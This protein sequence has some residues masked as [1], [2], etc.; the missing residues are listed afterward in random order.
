LNGL[1]K[2]ISIDV[3]LNVPE[4]PKF[5]KG[6]RGA[7]KGLAVVN[8]G[9][10]PELIEGR[11]GSFRMVESKGAAL[12]YLNDGDRVYT[13][14]QTRSIMRHV[15]HYA[16]GIGNYE[17]VSITTFIDK[18]PE[19]FDKAHDE[20]ELRRDMDLITEEEYYKELGRLRDDFFAESSDKWWEYTE[21]IYSWE[22]DNE[23]KTLDRRLK[24]GE[25]S[26]KEY[27]EALAE[28]RDKY[29]EEG[30]DEWWD[31][32][33][34]IRDYNKQI[35]EDNVQAM[36][37]IT[38]A[39]NDALKERKELEEQYAK[40]IKAI[41]DQLASDIK[42]R[43]EDL[44]SEKQGIIQDKYSAFGLFDSAEHKKVNGEE[45]WKGLIRQVNHMESFDKNLEKIREK[46]ASEEF[47]DEL[48]ALGPSYYAEI[49]AIA[50]MSDGLFTHYLYD[51]GKKHKLAEKLSADDIKKAEDNAENDIKK[52]ISDAD[53]DKKEVD[54]TFKENIGNIVSD[55]YDTTM[56]EL[57]DFS[58]VGHSII[59]GIVNGINEDDGVLAQALLEAVQNAVDG[60]ELFGG[61]TNINASATWE[62]VVGTV[63][64]SPPASV[65]SFIPTIG[66]PMVSEN[67]TSDSHVEAVVELDG[68][69]VGRAIFPHIT[70][71]SQRVGPSLVVKG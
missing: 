33:L 67:T 15:P 47:I 11:D 8:D 52:L 49:S 10:G 41:E 54:A 2:N 62:S 42:Q 27:Y 50:N 60:Y 55:L 5:A 44:E 32:T 64:S 38:N 68:T 29:F 25:I 16:K 65:T 22:K 43:Y 39:F 17:T 36:E 20:L 45:L 48:R 46:G 30:S 24:L 69:K 70:A 57:P 7:K 14:E 21:K 53:A 26:E 58:G 61:G 3:K 51:W 12:T 37:S 66:L 35:E 28:Y 31:Y 34:E 71:E 4:L 18:V 13:A 63:Y 1:P 56:E 6:T 23:K 40:D 9:N 19:A 59:E